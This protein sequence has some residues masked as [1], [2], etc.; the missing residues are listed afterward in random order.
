MDDRL[1][2]VLGRPGAAAD[3]RRALELIAKAGA[4]EASLDLIAGIPG[5]TG[6]R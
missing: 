4:G 5:Q 1:L 2:A 3:N 6:K